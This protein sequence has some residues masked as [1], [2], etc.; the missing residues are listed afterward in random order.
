V[1]ARAVLD[2][3][4]SEAEWQRTVTEYATLR[5]WRWFHDNDSR[6]NRS[7]LPD[8]LMVRTGRI[9]FAELKSEKGR[10]R[11]E[12]QDWLNDLE[13]CCVEAYLWRPSDWPVVERVLA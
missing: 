10:V 4:M 6:L 7:G 11:P 2:R 1:T 8:L 12:Q 9:V 5:G 13:V 3:A